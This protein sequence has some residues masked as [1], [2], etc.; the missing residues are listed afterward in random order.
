MRR[1]GR[2]IRT[3]KQ[4]VERFRSDTDT[5]DNEVYRRLRLHPMSGSSGPNKD[6]HYD[7]PKR[8]L[9]RQY[10]L[11]TKPVGRRVSSG[12]ESRSFSKRKRSPWLIRSLVLFCFLFSIYLLIRLQPFT[13]VG[14]ARIHSIFS[15]TY[16]LNTVSTRRKGCHLSAGAVVQLRN[17]PALRMLRAH[18]WLVSRMPTPHGVIQLRE[19]HIIRSIMRYLGIAAM[20]A[21]QLPQIP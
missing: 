20:L 14:T 19:V 7:Q 6:T 16:S 10:S 15:S 18:L 17:E 4:V 8:P 2:R 3:L 11:G 5:N 9:K 21:T 12:L 13:S 1:C